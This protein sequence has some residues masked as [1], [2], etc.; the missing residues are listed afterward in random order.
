MSDHQTPL[1]AV[2][3]GLLLGGSSTFL[4]NLARA[5]HQRGVT[6]PVIVHSEDN[7]HA[8]D[9]SAFGGTVKLI[10]RTRSIYEDRLR[11][12]YRETARWQPRAVMACLGSESFELLRVA[13]PGCGRIGVIQSHD[14]APYAMA[15]QFASC[16]DL[17]VGVSAEIC[18]HLR[19]LPDFSRCRIE[20]IPYGIPFGPPVERLVLLPDQPLRVVYLG[21]LIEEQKRVS[22]LVELV[23]LLEQRELNC[24]FSFVGS[25]PELTRMKSALAGSSNVEFYGEIPNTEVP[26]LLAAHDIFV[27]LSD[28]EGLPL[29]LLEAMGQGV[30]PVISDLESG[31]RDVV[32][33]DCGIR[34]PVGDVRAAAEVISALAHDRRRLNALSAAASTHARG[35]FSSERMALRYLQAVDTLA[36]TP[37]AWPSVVSIPTPIG[38]RPRWLFSG[39]PRALRRLAKRLAH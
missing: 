31:I 37:V 25:G 2:T 8:A 10:S 39:L 3:G 13:P 35:N 7:A 15:R 4:V 28:Y 11:L 38:V 34:V 14:P 32:K 23:K 12:A 30:V 33:D 18:R 27:L 6:L 9:F 26:R 36:T 16:I 29:S 24:R 21:R 5:F 20:Q 22:R 1:V 19:S 17:M